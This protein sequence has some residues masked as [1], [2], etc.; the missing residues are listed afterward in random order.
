[1]R[2]VW[3]NFFFFPSFSSFCGT[4]RI[5]VTASSHAL[6]KQSKFT[7][8]LDAVAAALS[9]KHH[10]IL[11]VGAGPIHLIYVLLLQLAADANHEKIL[12]STIFWREFSPI[13]AHVRCFRRHVMTFAC[14]V[15]II[16][17]T[18][19]NF[20]RLTKDLFRKSSTPL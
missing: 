17:R 1:M 3:F 10:V 7:L 9:H 13:C 8:A 4:M 19:Q 16:T 11:H 14:L 12:F 18:V 2:K 6:K 5:C 20:G 15:L